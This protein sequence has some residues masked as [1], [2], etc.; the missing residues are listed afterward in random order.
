MKFIQY[1]KYAYENAPGD[2]I[3]RPFYLVLFLISLLIVIDT[4]LCF[5]FGEKVIL[6]T[7]VTLVV[8]TAFVYVVKG[9]AHLVNS[10]RNFINQETDALA[11]KLKGK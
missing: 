3:D 7:G 6:I 9:I 2:K 11:K 4:P 8:I 5:I 1:I 10:Y